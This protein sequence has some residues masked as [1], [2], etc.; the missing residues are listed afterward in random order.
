MFS[1]EFY[2]ISK[3][4]F[5]Y[6]TPLVAASVIFSMITDSPLAEKLGT[7]ERAR[8]YFYNCLLNLNYQ[9]IFRFGIYQV[10]YN[11][12]SFGKRLSF[13][14]SAKYF[15]RNFKCLF[16]KLSNFLSCTLSLFNVIKVRRFKTH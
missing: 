13:P 1:C 8:R 5:F 14:F 6:R 10:T 3:N 7:L 4:T 11:E 12:E 9:N 16:Q 2:E 15:Y